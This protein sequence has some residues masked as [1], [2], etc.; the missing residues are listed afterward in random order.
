MS[1]KQ[2]GNTL[3]FS[4]ML[5]SYDYKKDIF[6]ITSKD[7]DLAGKPFQITLNNTS[8]S[9]ATIRELFVEK[10][11]IKETENITIP[12]K[13]EYQ[14]SSKYNEIPLGVSYNGNHVWNMNKT[15]NLLINGH[16]GTGSSL[17][18]RLIIQHCKKFSN[19]IDLK[20][21]G[22]IIE[23]DKSV[24]DSYKIHSLPS[25]ISAELLKIKNI[26]DD[27]YR[28]ME[29]AGVS[30]FEKLKNK[31]KSIVVFINDFSYIINKTYDKNEKDNIMYL[32]DIIST[33]GR[34]AGVSI[35][36][37][38]SFSKEIDGKLL[39]QLTGRII[40]RNT[41][42]KLSQKYLNSDRAGKGQVQAGYAYS[43]F[44]EKGYPEKYPTLFSM[45][46]LK[47]N[48]IISKSSWSI[49]I[50]FDANNVLFNTVILKTVFLKKLSKIT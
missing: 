20:L 43:N 18:F 30:S 13:S 4:D 39:S 2:R 25:N 7:K 33:L 3:K 31:P 17:F 45:Y 15:P 47:E 29:E 10:G 5:V 35:V 27:R 1:K 38:D 16:V 37:K 8:Q 48:G 40:T 44:G 42:I 34:A 49:R 46:Y 50:D 23:F 32:L 22:N 11:I 6:T 19:E 14:P 24:R 12:L 36:I 26:V 21:F 28:E 41:D 9:E